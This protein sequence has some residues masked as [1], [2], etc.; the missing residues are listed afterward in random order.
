MHV[1]GCDVSM[2]TKEKSYPKMEWLKP[3]DQEWKFHCN[4][5]YKKYHRSLFCFKQIELL[6]QKLPGSKFHFSHFWTAL[7]HSNFQVI[8][9][10]RMGMSSAF[11]NIARKAVVSTMPTALFNVQAPWSSPWR[12]LYSQLNLNK[13]LCHFK[14]WDHG[15]SMSCRNLL[16]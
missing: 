7:L 4:F 15:S 13:G 11:S 9:K 8:R 12:K 3:K 5:G 10:L 16:N 14:S 2:R 6:E 1:M